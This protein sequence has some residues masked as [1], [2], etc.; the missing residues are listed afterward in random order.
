MHTSTFLFLVGLVLFFILIFLEKNTTNVE[1]FETDF[2]NNYSVV[3]RRY[4]INS[5]NVVSL[6]DKIHYDPSQDII[7]EVLEGSGALLLV[8]PDGTER[9]ESPAVEE[10]V[11]APTPEPVVAPTPEPVVAPTPEPVVA[12]TPEPVVAPTPEPVVAP[13]PE[14][15]VAPTPEP[16][17]EP[18]PV[19][20]PNAKGGQ[21]MWGQ[22]GGKKWSG[23]TECETGSECVKKNEWY[24][25]CKP[26]K[27]QSGKVKL[28]GKCGGKKYNGPTEC[29]EVSTCVKKNEWYSQCKP[30]NESFVT[31]LSTSSSPRNFV[32]NSHDSH[33]AILHVPLPSS[34]SVFLHVMNL[35]TNKHRS[36]LYFKNTE[37]HHYNYTGENIYPTGASPFSRQYEGFET[38]DAVD[39]NRDDQYNITHGSMSLT[40]SFNTGSQQIYVSAKKDM[41]VFRAY[42]KE[43]NGD[44]VIVSIET[45]DKNSS[46]SCGA[47][48]NKPIATPNSSDNN[49]QRFSDTLEMI[50]QLN[51]KLNNKDSNYILKTEVV[52]PVCPA[53]PSCPNSG[54]CSDCGGNGGSGTKG[55]N[56]SLIRDAGS[57][58]TNLIRDA[59]SGATDLIRDTGSGVNS[60]VRDTASGTKQS[61]ADIG[62]FAK[63]TVGDIGSFAK[64][65]VG[66]IGSFAKDT[67]GGIADYSQDVAGGLYGVSKDVVG[68]TVGLGKDVVG[69]TVGLGKD[70]V[71]GTVGL[72]KDVV[73]GIGNALTTPRYNGPQTYGYSNSYGGPNIRNG[74]PPQ[75]GRAYGP[76]YDQY[77]YF[78]ALEPRYH[79]QQY[80]PRTA[81]FSSFGK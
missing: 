10:P 71:G 77:S 64:D 3:L 43:E 50:Q 59:G 74:M 73:G 58:A 65:T 78:G 21:K 20:V 32:Y 66:G 53:C 16:E 14:P 1:G 4:S 12:P 48:Q 19:P 81:D 24:S 22:C 35:R 52:P 30:V 25:Q 70:V 80:I 29:T 33:Y 18:E 38:V 46:A 41:D 54:I 5:D 69:G 17:P 68:G 49:L 28:W 23:P 76:G 51:N 79:S 39:H 37:M 9:Q 31:R 26:K 61:L 7:I 62:S 55:N 40:T 44:V 8:Y 56:G 11:V 13:T 2:K 42:M 63:D 45:Q 72:G 15:V 57:G 36:T 75:V 60:L 6:T 27:T 67:V 34:N 47:N